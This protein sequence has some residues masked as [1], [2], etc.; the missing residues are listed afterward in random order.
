[1]FWGLIVLTASLFSFFK[2]LV[3]KLETWSAIGVADLTLDAP[4]ICKI[5]IFRFLRTVLFCQK[6]FLNPS[7]LHTDYLPVRA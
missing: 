1:M 3:Q 5:K 6:V 2:D 4:K 7:A